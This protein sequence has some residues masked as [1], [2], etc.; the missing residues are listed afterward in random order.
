MGHDTLLGKPPWFGTCRGV[1]KE[2]EPREERND[3]QQATTESDS[4]V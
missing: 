3:K 1:V 4:K 2:G